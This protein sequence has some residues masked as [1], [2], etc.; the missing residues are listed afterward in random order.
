MLNRINKLDY[1]KQVVVE[2]DDCA[3]HTS[4][5]TCTVMLQHK[6]EF[7]ALVKAKFCVINQT[8]PLPDPN[9]KLLVLRS[10]AYFCWNAYD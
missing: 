6:M 3:K 7:V 5:W 4:G 9:T 8:I 2:V 1:S 10:E